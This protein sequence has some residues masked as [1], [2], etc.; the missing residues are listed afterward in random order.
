MAQDRLQKI[1]AHAGVASRRAAEELILAGRVSVNGKVMSELGARADPERDKIELDGK[2]ITAENLVYYVVHKPR[3]MVT[4]LSDPEDRPTIA[5]L[6][7]DVPERVYPIGRLDFHTSGA[8]LVTN[9]GALAEALLHPKRGVKKTYVAKLDKSP[10]TQQ[11]QALRL[12]VTLDDG[13]KTQAASVVV[14]REEDGHPWLEITISEGKNRQIHR[15]A[16]AVGLRVMRLVRTV[17]AGIDAGGLRPGQLRPLGEDEVDTLRHTYLGIL[18][19]KPAP[20]AAPRQKG[21]RDGARTKTPTQATRVRPASKPREEPSTSASR[22]RPVSE[23]M[24]ADR[25]ASERVRPAAAKQSSATREAEPANRRST[26]MH[27]AET[28]EEGQRSM[29]RTGVAPK[30]ANPGGKSSGRR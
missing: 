19:A 2:R 25:G 22:V 21:A 3:A 30:R 26:G 6:L 16:E 11:L 27:A 7:G 20:R 9:D 13:Y 17:F 14:L 28:L 1:L 12:G 10:D 23:R 24:S 5:E 29:R 18:P 15:M 4:T 8:L